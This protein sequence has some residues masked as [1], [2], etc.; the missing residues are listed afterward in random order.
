MKNTPDS[1]CGA[2]A[3]IQVAEGQCV[4]RTGACGKIFDPRAAQIVASER[5]WYRDAMAR[6]LQL[7]VAAALGS[8][9]A[10]AT[11]QDAATQDAAT[12]SPALGVVLH[13]K[14]FLDSH[15][16]VRNLDELGEARATVIVFVTPDCPLARR[17]LSL[18][19]ELELA[20]RSR[21]VRFVGLDPSVDA[22]VVESAAAGVAAGVE[23][24]MGVDE[25]GALAK[26]LSVVRTPTVCVL[27][28]RMRAVYVG[29]VDASLRQGGEPVANARADLREALDDVLADRPVRVA[30]TVV[31]GC[32]L[33]FDRAPDATAPTWAERVGPLVREHCASCHA[34]GGVAPFELWDYRDGARRKERIEEV[35]RRGV[36]P[37]WHASRTA[38]EFANARRLPDE[39]REAIL[40]WARG[41]APA[42][43]L[44]AHPDPARPAAST[45]WKIGEPDLV[46]T[47]LGRTKLPASGTVPYQYVLIPHAF[48]EDTWVE[49]VEI[50]PE[51]T[52][53][54][55]H[56]NLGW[57]R[58]G[59]EFTPENFITGYVPGGDV[60]ELEPGQAT[61]IPAGAVLG[62]QAHFVTTGTETSNRFRVGLRFPRTRIERR[63]RHLEIS[64]S[65]FAIP[66]FEPAHAVDATRKFPGAATGIGMFVHM[67]LRGRDVD[68]R[69]LA[70][71]G[72]ETPLLVVPNYD[73]D[74]QSS[75]RWS[76][77]TQHFPAETRVKARA[78]FDNSKFNP[79]NPDPSA[80]VKVGQET[81]DEMM[82]VFLFYTLDDE[83]LGLDVDPRT[84]FAMR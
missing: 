53:A 28:A 25:G 30:S 18:L 61:L 42:G 35:V 43:D 72:R 26:A 66:P 5:G 76:K 38:G 3:R 55:H 12:Q 62:L 2:S 82:Y 32:L 54:V 77:N 45:A 49:A 48:T 81:V 73:F 11:A 83:H 40:A 20:L 67:H 15:N 6:I 75:Y 14:T 69:E 78:R 4:V 51:D 47:Q 56:A 29:R 68:V 27:D 80:R 8:L 39:A 21:G 59:A 33:T 71:D 74:W 34:P 44:V 84:G 19:A 10:L 58:L 16:L 31:D 79:F 23:F 7:V 13:E 24:P 17:S 60:Y 41:G 52:R 64:N 37:P 36:M 70:P 9:L 50:R 65:R 1:R 63:A 57:V 22:S 46:L